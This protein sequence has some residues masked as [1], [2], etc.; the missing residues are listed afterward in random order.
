MAQFWR[1]PTVHVVLD[2]IPNTRKWEASPGSERESHKCLR[3]RDP[4]ASRGPWKVK[5]NAKLIKGCGWKAPDTRM[6]RVMGGVAL[7]II[8]K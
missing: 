6:W 3:D 8:W 1:L 2:S 7:S 4:R 5:G